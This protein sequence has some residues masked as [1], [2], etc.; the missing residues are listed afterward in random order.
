MPR[1]GSA[2]SGADLP[3]R[4][5]RIAVLGEFLPQRLAVEADADLKLLVADV[6]QNRFRAD[7]KELKPDAIVL[8]LAT[9]D[10]ATAALV[11]EL[12]KCAGAGVVLVVYSYGRRRTFRWRRKRRRCFVHR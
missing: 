9:V 10:S 1:P 7:V 4:Q 11:D 6:D 12:K 5:L 3:L 8:E 2:E